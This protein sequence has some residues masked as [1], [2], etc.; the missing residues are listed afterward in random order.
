VLLNLHT[1]TKSQ[2]LQETN[3]TWSPDSLTKLHVLHLCKCILCCNLL[4]NKINFQK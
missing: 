4:N 2:K 1:K 3:Y